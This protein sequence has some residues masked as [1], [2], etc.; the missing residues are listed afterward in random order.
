MSCVGLLSL[1]H[2]NEKRGGGSVLALSTLPPLLVVFF[3]CL[4]EGRV[5]P[6]HYTSGKRLKRRLSIMSVTL[7]KSS[8]LSSNF[9]LSPSTITKLPV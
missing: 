7:R 8:A 6:R 3:S 4:G 2:V 9:T 5:P 1:K